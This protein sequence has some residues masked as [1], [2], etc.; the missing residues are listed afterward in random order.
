MVLLVS[1]GVVLPEITEIRV[2]SVEEI[3]ADEKYEFAVYEV[4]SEGTDGTAVTI[5]KKGPY[6]AASCNAVAGTFSVQPTKVDSNPRWTLAPHRRG[7]AAYKDYPPDGL[8]P[9]AIADGR[10]LAIF[11]VQAP[12]VTT[13]QF[14]IIFE[15]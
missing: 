7:E 12:S 13:W 1:D 4:S 15:E 5:T 14:D 10:G 2:T 9:T 3:P 6:A 11:C 8:K